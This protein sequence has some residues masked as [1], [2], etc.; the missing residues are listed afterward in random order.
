M[1]SS[2][3]N[4][5]PVPTGPARGSPR[6][7]KTSLTPRT[8][9]HRAVPCHRH[10]GQPSWG[11]GS[12][13]MLVTARPR[14]VGGGYGR[15]QEGEPRPSGTRERLPASCDR[16]R[17]PGAG[18]TSSRAAESTRPFRAIG[19]LP[20]RLRASRAT[21][22]RWF[23]ARAGRVLRVAKLGP[24]PTRPGMQPLGLPYLRRRRRSMSAPTRVPATRTPPTA[25][26]VHGGLE[27]EGPGRTS[28]WVGDRTMGGL[29]EL[30]LAL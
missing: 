30:S 26:A 21:A 9:S 20:G 6:R 24:L 5:A 11:L 25:T 4:S 1:P 13:L 7:A 19:A 10:D 15:R 29:V 27:P 28:S 3:M 2:Y 12:P 16:S 14:P 22:A 17:P 8:P 23:P 18:P